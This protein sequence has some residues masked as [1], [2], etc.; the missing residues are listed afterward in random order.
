MH[1]ANSA[2]SLPLPT[3]TSVER[4]M[5]EEDFIV[6]KTDTKGKI[7]YGNPIFIEFSGYPEKAL[8]GAPHKIVRHPDM[9][10]CVFALL[11]QYLLRGE[12]I[13]AYVKNLCAD[14]SYYWVYANATASRNPAGDIIGYYS[15]RRKPSDQAMQIIPEL[16]QQLLTAE[17][18]KKGKAQV[19]AGVQALTHLLSQKRVSYEHFVYQLQG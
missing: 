2:P 8:L 9:P 5:R 15:V 18:G 16:Y 19:E 12:E 1:T 13:F 10:R 14:G 17:S 6:S 4:K 11:W 7:T 3:P